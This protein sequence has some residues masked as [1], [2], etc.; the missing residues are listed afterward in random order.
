[1][2]AAATAVLGVMLAL[3]IAAGH[4]VEAREA[5]GD[6][7]GD[8][9]PLAISQSGSAETANVTTRDGI[10]LRV[11]RGASGIRVEGRFTT[12]ASA[13]AAWNVL[14]DYDSIERFVSS[15]R[16]S[17][18]LC[19]TGDSVLVSQEAIGRLMLFSRRL[20]ATLR[21]HESRPASIVFEDVL[22]KDFRSYHGEWRIEDAPG[23]VA[24]TY[25]L[26][27]A[28]SFS[29]PDFV[30]RGLFRA[31]A[32]DLLSQVRAEIHRRAEIAAR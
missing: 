6:G 8:S 16:D 2:R 31:T 19:R 25:R 32:F 1:M 24:V 9:A 20:H 12:D 17:R 14:T 4:G 15:M 13:L 11:S 7:V 18:V 22:Q 3:A 21:I 28:P 30:A 10:E 23:G 5:S 29:I 27:A 26:E